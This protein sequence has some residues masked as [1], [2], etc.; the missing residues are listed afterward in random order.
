M[1]GASEL[2][3]ALGKAGFLLAIGSSGPPENV[4]QVL[5]K[6]Q[7]RPLLSAVVTGADVTRG[8]PD[9][10]VFL[11]AAQRLGVHPARCVVVE[12]AALGIKAA[13]AA[14]MKAIG[15]ASTGRTRE[16]LAT[17]D[18]VVDRLGEITPAMIRSLMSFSR[19]A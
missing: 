8:K 2:L 4:D 10:Q 15:L 17:A 14:G 11:I 16:S 18:L 9:P 13:H 7:I 19:S 1:P 3:N 6:L 5:D 12:D